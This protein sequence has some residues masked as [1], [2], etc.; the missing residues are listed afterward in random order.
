MRVGVGVALSVVASVA[1]ILMRCFCIIGV[2]ALSLVLASS[3][4]GS[5]AGAVGNFSL[6]ALNVAS[7]A[8]CSAA[9]HA[10][11]LVRILIVKGQEHRS[12]TDGR[13]CAAAFVHGRA[14]FT[15][16]ACMLTVELRWRAARAGYCVSMCGRDALRRACVSRQLCARSIAVDM[17]T[18]RCA[19]LLAPTVLSDASGVM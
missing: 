15:A 14:A 8:L 2:A 7:N 17:Y 3:V 16:A 18:R 6:L 9:A 13:L 10:S 12:T 11:S 4:A 19:R 1:L 5:P